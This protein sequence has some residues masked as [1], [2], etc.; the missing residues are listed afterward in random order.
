MK[1]RPWWHAILAKTGEEQD[2]KDDD[3]RNG[4]N[5]DDLL[6][7]Q[8]SFIWEMYRNSQ[9][10]KNPGQ[11]KGILLNH[12]QKNAHL[13]TKKGLYLSI[14]NYC[15]ENSLDML[16]MIPLTFYLAPGEHKPN[17][18]KDDD[19]E[20]FQS[21]C[22]KHGKE[23]GLTVNEINFIMKPASKTNRGFGIKVVKGM[24]KVLN[25]VQR[26]L[27]ACSTGG[28]GEGEQLPPSSSLENSFTAEDDNSSV[29]VGGGELPDGIAAARASGPLVKNKSTKRPSNTKQSTVDAQENDPLSKAAKK[30]AQQDG[31]IVQLYL[32]SPMLV[33]GR[34]FDIRCFV[35]C[36]V[37]PVGTSGEKQLKAH[38]FQEAYIRTSSKKY[39]LTNLYDRE[40]HLT[41]D[42]VQKHSSSYGKYESGNKLSLQEWQDF[43]NEDVSKGVGNAT[44]LPSG[45][46][47]TNNIVFD[48]I[49]PEIKNLCRH[50]IAAVAKT[51]ETTDIPKSFELF[52]YDFMILENYQ[53][54]LI[55]VNTNPCLEFVNPLLTNI[56][57][58]VIEHSIRMTVDKEFPPPPK[59]VRTKATEEAVQAIEAEPLKFEP[60]YP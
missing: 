31:Y 26:G 47:S 19:L 14:R 52:G 22:E 29:K 30:I 34:K 7:H 2:D 20:E 51:F 15:R 23:N 17:S 45:V 11:Y 57:S 42:A 50:S 36:T 4:D 38:F 28:G 54:I 53:P 60:L 55:E 3:S 49:F 35:L 48:Y 44:N 37:T 58:T 39:N 18:M 33:H 5:S 12:I 6:Q 46:T 8:P 27:S 1:K 43:I 41:N 21:F 40:V 56:I 9:R 10:Y 16:S 13:V 24:T 25:V 59:S 32:N